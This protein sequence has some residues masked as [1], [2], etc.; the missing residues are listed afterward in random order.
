M[1]R[2]HTNYDYDDSSSFSLDSSYKFNKHFFRERNILLLGC[3]TGREDIN[4]AKH[5]YGSTGAKS[6]IAPKRA[7]YSDDFYLDL[8]ERGRLGVYL[9]RGVCRDDCRVYGKIN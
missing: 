7:I 6:I 4:I 5:I 3:K 2:K 9:G 8:N 1:R